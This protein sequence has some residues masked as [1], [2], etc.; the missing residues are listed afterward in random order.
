MDEPGL[1]ARL[2][3]CTPRHAGTRLGIGD[4]AALLAPP[5]EGTLLVVAADTLVEAV[6]FPT[7]TAAAVIAERALASNLSDMA[8]MGARPRAFTLAL[9]L[10]SAE[11]AWVDAFADHLGELAQRHGIELIGG[12]T[13]RGPVVVVTLQV[14]GEVR[15]GEALRRDGARPGD[16]LCLSG[17]TGEAALGLA[18]LLDASRSEALHPAERQRLLARFE[19][20]EPRLALGLALAGVATAA[21]DV[22]DGLLADLEHL[23]TAS[24]CGARVNLERLPT[25][26]ALSAWPDAAQALDAR[27]AGGDDYELLFT[28]PP[29][30]AARIPFLEHE[31]RVDISVIGSI[32]ARKGLEVLDLDGKPLAPARRGYRHF[33]E[34][35]P[36]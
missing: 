26:P 3:E 14:L 19:A 21:I 12:D 34:R 16:L 32:T 18:C 15:E 30:A 36:G 7:G 6:H 17:V 9:T 22:S 31:G 10:P 35:G 29:L 25:S 11:P 23:C 27:L 33:A 24:G 20:P 28:L 2:R 4:D 8:A 1:I 5:A 13:T